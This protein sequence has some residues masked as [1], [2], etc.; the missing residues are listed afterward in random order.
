LLLFAIHNLHSLVVFYVACTV[1]SM[2]TLD[3]VDE[4]DSIAVKVDKTSEDDVFEVSQ[5]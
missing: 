2:G 3:K 4:E 1:H 5:L